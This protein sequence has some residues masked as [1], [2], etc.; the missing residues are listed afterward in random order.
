M[1][2]IRYL[3]EQDGQGFVDVRVTMT[4]AIIALP[5][6]L[7][8]NYLGIKVLNG[9]QRDYFILY[10]GIWKNKELSVARIPADQNR[11][12]KDYERFLHC[13]AA[14]E[15][16]VTVKDMPQWMGIYRYLYNRRLTDG[17]IG[18]ITGDNRYTASGE[19]GR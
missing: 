17:V 18:T 15:G 4:G 8:L 11:D 10:E 7:K 12:G 1:P 19:Q 5:S 13:G 9:Q 3:P 14:S 2:E 16:C 6:Y